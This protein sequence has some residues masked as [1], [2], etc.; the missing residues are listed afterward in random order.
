MSSF[1]YQVHV[2]GLIFCF[3]KIQRKANGG[4]QRFNPI[5]QFR[6]TSLYVSYIFLDSAPNAI[7]YEARCNFQLQV[8]TGMMEHCCPFASHIVFVLGRNSMQIMV[9]MCAT[10]EKYSMSYRRQARTNENMWDPYVDDFEDVFS[11][12]LAEVLQQ[13]VTKWWSWYSQGCDFQSFAVFVRDTLR[14]QSVFVEDKSSGHPCCV[15]AWREVCPWTRYVHCHPF[16]LSVSQ[17]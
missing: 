2:S 3:I 15:E 12:R 16:L 7:M 13:Q 10:I 11:P 4:L 1:L 9:K 6:H 14:S 8:E 17:N 5:L